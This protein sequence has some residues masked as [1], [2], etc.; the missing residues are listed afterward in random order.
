M[1]YN[2][3]KLTISQT[4]VTGSSTITLFDSTQHVPINHMNGM[5]LNYFIL[6][7]QNSDNTLDVEYSIDGGENWISYDSVAVETTAVSGEI[8]IGH[9]EHIRV[10]FTA[11]STD[12]TSFDCKLDID[13][14]S[15]QPKVS[16]SFTPSDISLSGWLRMQN[17]TDTGTLEIEDVINSG[18][19]AYQAT[20]SQKP[21]FSTSNGFTTC[22]FDGTDDQIQWDKAGNLLDETNCGF[23]F[24]FRFNTAPSSEEWIFAETADFRIISLSATST[25]LRVRVLG[26]TPSTSVQRRDVTTS[27]GTDWHF[28]VVEYDGS[29]VSEEDRLSITYDGTVEAGT[30]V[31]EGGGDFIPSTIRTT[32]GVYIGSRNA[33][34]SEIEIGD[35]YGTPI[36]GYLTTAQKTN[37]QNFE[38]RG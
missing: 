37:L 21:T 28:V 17:N 10:T 32:N 22:V 33:A 16:S 8:F 31:S 1:F 26:D 2:K 13:S 27:V 4:S 38:A 6:V 12:I 15:R 3:T 20:A 19:P 18:N 14:T 11:G 25:I 35:I 24:W 29:Q 36:S 34:H 23:A 5:W 9:F 7:N 30:D